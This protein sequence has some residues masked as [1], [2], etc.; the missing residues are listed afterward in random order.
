MRK[1]LA[2]LVSVGIIQLLTDNNLSK[3]G[4]GY[5]MALVKRQK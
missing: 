5:L 1:H 2:D 3:L 4:Q